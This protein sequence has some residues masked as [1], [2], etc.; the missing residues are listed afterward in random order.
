MI[1]SILYESNKRDKIISNLKKDN[2]PIVIYGTGSFGKSV[3]EK[4]DDLGLQILC[5]MDKDEYWFESKK[6]I[7]H[8]KKIKCMRKKDVLKLQETYNLL[9][10]IIDYSLLEHLKNEFKFCNYVEY[11]DLY[12]SHIIEENFLEA[13]SSILEEIYEKLE[14]NE[15]KN[16]LNAFLKARYAGNIEKLSNLYN[17]GTMYDWKLLQLSKEDTII[18]G[19]AY[20]GDTIVEIYEYLGNAIPTMIYEF[21]PDK[22]NISKLTESVSKYNS[23]NILIIE[24]ALYDRDGGIKFNTQGNLGSSISDEGNQEVNIQ[25]IDNHLEYKDVS[26][27]KMD[28][29]GSELKALQGAI[30]LIK[31]NHPRMAICIY[32]NNRDLIDIYCLLKKFGY[33]FYLRQ[34]SH[35]VEETVLYA[36]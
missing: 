29:E 32:H 35:S 20:V 3:A 5:F 26:I 30:R 2:K 25:A 8:E 1:E 7:V 13:N 28:I 10:A 27:I 36:I 9:L 12:E 11:L 23:S 15:S 34:H 18:D 21:E 16:V 14:D 22:E 24:A 19:G 4:I 6:I 33:H 31:R 17:E